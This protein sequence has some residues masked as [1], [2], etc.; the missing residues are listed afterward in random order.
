MNRP[1]SANGHLALGRLYAI[2][3]VIGI[4]VAAIALAVLYRELSIRVI[5]E[6][7]E[8][9]NVTVAK[10]VLNAFRPELAEYLLM[11][12]TATTI[13][14]TD[15]PT[16]RLSSLITESVRDTPIVRIKIYN[17]H[18]IVLYST[19]K[20]EIGTD[21]SANLEFQSALGGN[22]RSKLMYRDWFGLFHR[23][24]DDDNLIE[25]YVPVRGA[26]Q[27]QPIGVLEIYTDVSPIVRAMTR[28]ELLVLLG[29]GVIMIILYSS[30]LYVVRR[31]ERV[32]AGQQRTIL[33]RTRTLELLSARMLAAED[34]ERRRIATELHE[35]IAQTLGAAKMRVEAYANTTAK[36]HPRSEPSASADIV[37][38]V[39]QAMREVRGLALDLR[40]PGL[41]D[42]GLLATT[43]SLCRESAEAHEDLAITADFAV[44]E[45]E[46]PPN[47][48]AIIFRILQ[49]TIRRVTRTPGIGELQ[50]AIKKQQ[51]QLELAVDLGETTAPEDVAVGAA[52]PRDDPIAAIW[53]RAV[54]SGASFQK[55]RIRGNGV[56]YCAEWLV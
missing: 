56:R 34:A 8:R 24:N 3:S 44:S 45:E 17:H 49:E 29:I 51:D 15:A 5:L 47:L 20:H 25:T 42:F 39:Q 6:F 18:G 22:V 2:A 11:E 26:G 7:G 31:S 28:A 21:D 9:S 32:I 10:T 38:L 52:E 43:R 50:I 33:D 55:S 35:E 23:G 19:R 30:L 41:D 37:P 12:H 54:L 36:P 53:E 1:P 27:R 14:P 40:P 48:K 46:I 16:P 13:G 4:L